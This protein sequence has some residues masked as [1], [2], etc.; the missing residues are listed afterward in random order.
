MVSF[1]S[2]GELNHLHVHQMPAEVGQ[3][4]L[5][6]SGRG[7]SHVNR[8]ISHLP[9]EDTKLHLKTV[10]QRRVRGRKSNRRIDVFYGLILYGQKMVT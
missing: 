7:A 4:N 5:Q 2:P 6:D 8:T 10:R 9:T 3:E 1:Y